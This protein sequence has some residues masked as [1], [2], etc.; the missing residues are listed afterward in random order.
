MSVMF[1]GLADPQALNQAVAAYQ[2][3]HFIGMPECD[4]SQTKSY[5]FMSCTSLTSQSISNRTTI[6]QTPDP[7]LYLWRNEQYHID[8]GRIIL[9]CYSY[10]VCFIAAL[11]ITCYLYL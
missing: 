10:E 8:Q 7:G 9:I 6:I 4:V 2:A 5:I 3:C 1:L 11:L